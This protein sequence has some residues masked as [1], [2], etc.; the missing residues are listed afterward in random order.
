MPNPWNLSRSE[1]LRRLGRLEQ[2][3][4]VR[5]VTLEDGAERGVRVLEFRLGN[6]FCFEV[7]LDRAFDIGRAAF[8]GQPLAWEGQVGFSGPWYYEPQ[9]L[10]FLRSFGGGLL[11]TCGLDH[12]LFP[13]DDSATQYHYPPKASEHYPLHGR[14]SNRPARLVGYGTRWEGEECLLWAE[15][16][17]LQASALGESLLLRR[18]IEA[19]LGGLELRIQ[20]EVVN[21][22]YHPTPHMLL[23]HV[24][25]GFPIVDQGSEL[26]LP[27]Q[28][29][30]AAGNYSEKGFQVLGSPVP[31]YEEQVF[32]YVPQAEP[33]GTVPVAII[34]RQRGIGAYQL[35]RLEQLPH[36]FVWR[37]LGE[38]HYVVALEPST[39]RVAGRLEAR[40]RGELIE[41]QPGQS[42]SYNLT[43]GVLEGL[44]AIEGFAGRV[45]RLSE[46]G[47]A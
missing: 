46:V 7:L 4:G 29:F 43:L 18:R 1:L 20:D 15:G 8:Q 3:A 40:E 23:Y 9:G 17:V 12:T 11:V 19:D 42:R 44:E 28:N 5:L 16:E 37:M 22:G 6:G 31:G 38:G 45:G 34:N 14:I 30:R 35:F 24:N 39:N 10:G 47:T 25:I 27:S 41:L 36:P 21:L 13:T 32:E 33:D 2:A 26:L